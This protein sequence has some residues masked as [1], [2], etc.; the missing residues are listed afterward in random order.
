MTPFAA[1]YSLNGV[2]FAARDALRDEAKRVFDRPVDFSVRNAF[3]YTRARFNGD[4]TAR[5]SIRDRQLA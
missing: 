3:G 4:M 5:I 1:S 2:V